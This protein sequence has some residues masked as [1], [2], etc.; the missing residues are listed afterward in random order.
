MHSI[1]DENCNCS[2][3]KNLTTHIILNIRQLDSAFQKLLFCTLKVMLSYCK[4]YTL[5]SQNN[6]YQAAETAASSFISHNRFIYIHK[7]TP[8]GSIRNTVGTVCR[9]AICK[10]G[11]AIIK[12]LRCPDISKPSLCRDSS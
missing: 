12:L 7:R 6:N 5:A 10:Q 8:S 1:K 9:T 3:A 11:N 2:H 4:S